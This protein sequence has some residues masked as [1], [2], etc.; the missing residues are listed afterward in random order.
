MKALTMID[1]YKAR[2][3]GARQSRVLKGVSILVDSGDIVL[4]EGPSGSGKTTFL[5]VAAGLLR[6]DSGTVEIN[7]TSINSLSLSERR[8]FRLR[9]V[10][11]IF[12]RLNLLTRLTAR[13]N[14][15][16]MAKLSGMSI[17]RTYRE[18][19]VLMNTLGINLLADRYPFELSV[20]EEQRVAIARALV[21]IPKIV[22]ADEPTGNLDKTSSNAVAEILASVAQAR[23]IAVIIA[24]H[25]TRLK[26]LAT[27]FVSIDDGLIYEGT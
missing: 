1:V 22:F 23:D 4:L 11:F 3:Y 21:H 9:N 15:L 19:D 20:G 17:E 18:T 13:Q 6:P 12:Q 24:T 25:D 26:K 8:K 10:G 5:S 7:G 16:L 27:R 2:G 14:I